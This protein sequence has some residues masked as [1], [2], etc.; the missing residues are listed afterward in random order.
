MFVLLVSRFIWETIAQPK[1][2]KIYSCVFFWEFY[3]FGF[4]IFIFNLFLVDFYFCWKVK[5]Q[6]HSFECGC[7]V[8]LASFVEKLIC[9]LSQHPWQL[10]FFLISGRPFNHHQWKRCWLLFLSAFISWV[11]LLLFFVVFLKSQIAVR[12]YQVHFLLR[13]LYDFSFL[14]FLIWWITLIFFSPV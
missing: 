9:S 5:F 3:R 13:W 7:H 1:V 12:F 11:R 4:Y 8:V 6:L 14:C 2:I 10:L